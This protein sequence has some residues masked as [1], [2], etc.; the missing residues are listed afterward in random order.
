M[1]NKRVIISW[2]LLIGW[3]LFIFCM[4]NQPAE[5]STK[6]S[7]LVIKLFSAIG[8]DLNTH[9]GSLASF[10]VRKAAHFT[11]YFILYYFAI[12]VCKNYVDIKRARIYSL[13]IVLG[14]AITDEIHQYFIP[15]RSMA[16]RDVIIDFSGGVFGFIINWVIYK[17]KY[18]KQNKYNV[19]A[20]IVS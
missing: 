7:D 2:T 18:K 10:I 17:L 8:I 11:E 12:L 1:K 16:I 19:K 15:G 9:L 14:Y 20:K 4:S 3:M 6:Q 5:V 13:F